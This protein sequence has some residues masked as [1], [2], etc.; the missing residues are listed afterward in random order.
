MN[1]IVDLLRD[2]GAD[3]TRDDAIAEILRLRRVLLVLAADFKRAGNAASHMAEMQRLHKAAEYCRASALTS[4][5]GGT[6]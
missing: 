5:D 6:P 1:D 4:H 3:L 2:P